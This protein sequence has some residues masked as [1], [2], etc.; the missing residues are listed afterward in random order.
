MTDPDTKLTAEILKPFGDYKTPGID[1]SVVELLRKA[2][3]MAE[4][5]EITGVA[6]AAIA[7][8]GFSPTRANRGTA[9]IGELIGTVA[10]LQAEMIGNWR[11][12]K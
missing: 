3:A 6:I 8:N 9:S 12:E 2:L 5:G 1:P 4:R 7:G 10:V 11:R